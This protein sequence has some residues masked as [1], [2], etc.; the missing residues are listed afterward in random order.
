M[1]RHVKGVL[2]VDYV[3]M[4]RG[5]KEQPWAAQLLPEDLPY[6]QERVVDG[7]WYPMETFERMG[8]AILRLVAGGDLELVRRWGRL[9]A[10]DVASAL[11]GLVVPGDPRETL[12]RVHVVRRSL[13]DFETLTVLEIDDGQAVLQVGFGMSPQAE[14]A[15]GVQTLGFFEGLVELADGR[16]TEAVLAERSWAGD[17][18]TVLRLAWELP[19]QS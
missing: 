13:F 16:P 2:F 11:E 9:S 3:R 4:L 15:A 7:A 6:L 19:A 10:A 5:H 18:C 12:M 17:S 8:L 14:E 1:A